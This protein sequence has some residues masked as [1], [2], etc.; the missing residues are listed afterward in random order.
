MLHF[1]GLRK[2]VIK[3]YFIIIIITV[4]LFEGL[5]IFYVQ[6]YYYDSVRQSL[7]SQVEYTNSVYNNSI[8]NIENTTFDEK[9]SNI[10][11]KQRVV[12]GLKY[13]IQVINKDK[14]IIID[15]YGIKKHEKIE[16]EDVDKALKSIKDVKD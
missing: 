2:K 14:Y 7:K 15:Q 4:T 9:I 16:A 3:N 13:A 5:F 6:N 12:G 1:E 8:N 11:E 10:L